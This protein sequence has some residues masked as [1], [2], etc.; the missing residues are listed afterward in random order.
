MQLMYDGFKH[1]HVFLYFI[2]LKYFS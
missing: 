2:F 1:V